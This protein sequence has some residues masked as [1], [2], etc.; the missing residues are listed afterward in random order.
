MAQIGMLSGLGRK[1]TSKDISK[2]DPNSKADPNAGLREEILRRA[3]QRRADE[4]STVVDD[5]LVTADESF[6]EKVEAF[7][8]DNKGL[9][10]M[11]IGALGFIAYTVRERRMSL[12]SPSMAGTRRRRNRR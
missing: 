7:V 8:M 9:V 3:Q 4:L 12:P 6:F 10:L 5:E 11:G 2:V 1:S